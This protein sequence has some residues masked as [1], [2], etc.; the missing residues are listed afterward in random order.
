M[1]KTVV[2][3]GVSLLDVCVFWGFVD[4]V[5]SFFFFFFLFRSTFLIVEKVWLDSLGR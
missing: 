5:A 2:R 3:V 1:R 4:D